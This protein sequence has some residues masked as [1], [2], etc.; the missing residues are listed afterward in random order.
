MVLSTAFVE[1]ETF[2]RITSKM[3]DYKFWIVLEIRFCNFYPFMCPLTRRRGQEINK[4]V[5]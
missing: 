5:N 3:Y 4:K 1:S 2:K